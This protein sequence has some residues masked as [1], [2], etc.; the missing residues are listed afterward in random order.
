MLTA[1]VLI[2]SIAVT[3]DLA[4]C[5]VKN[6]A[7]VMRVPG[8]FGHPAICVM[9]TQAF[10]AATSIGQDLGANYRVRV[11]CRPIETADEGAQSTDVW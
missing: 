10:L 1:L 4:D 3:P 5:V 7:I 8:E 2:C 9:R 11:V 6:A